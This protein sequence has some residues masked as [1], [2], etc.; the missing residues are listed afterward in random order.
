MKVGDLVEL[1]AS[2]KKL[3]LNTHA[4]NKAGLV[5]YLYDEDHIPDSYRNAAYSQDEYCLDVL[6]SGAQKIQPFSHVRS[7]L[8]HMK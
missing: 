6:W 1:S 8:K 3:H 4:V 7:D 2:G 5:I